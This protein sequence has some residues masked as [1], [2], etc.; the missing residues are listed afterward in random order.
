LNYCSE[1]GARVGR[2]LP[3]TC[4]ACG[5]THY[6]NARPTACA[7]VMHDGRLLLVKRGRD[8][9]GG[10]WDI[11][12]GFC[13]GAEHP[14]DAARREVREEA[15]VDCEIGEYLGSWLDEYAPEIPTLNAYY[16]ATAASPETRVPPGQEIVEAGWFTPD[17]LPGPIAFPDSQ[18][19]VL[20][21]WR[22]ALSRR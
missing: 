15:G 3:T 11:P 21:A 4:E 10:C 22:A 16:H 7:L 5:T 12:G 14:V 6:L 1:C 19:R 13:D 2:P 17:E 8:P 9:W 18:L 20:D